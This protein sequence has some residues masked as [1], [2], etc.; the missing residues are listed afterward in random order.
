VLQRAFTL[1]ELIVVIGIFAVIMAV[2][3][4]N[5][6]ALNS[7]ILIN[8]FAYEIALNIRE[9]QAY[10]IGVRAQGDNVTVDS[11]KGAFAIY[12]TTQEPNL[13]ILYQDI[14]DDHAYQV[15][16]SFLR[17]Q[18]PKANGSRITAIC[19]NHSFVSNG[20]CTTASPTSDTELSISFKR[21]N[22]EA[23]FSSSD[24]GP[25]SVKSG[26]AVIVVN[27]ASGKN[28]KAVVVETTGQIHIESA[29]SVYPACIN[30]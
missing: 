27:N 19:V 10:G 20:P 3:M 11:F 14:N 21:P 15:D 18:L 4:Y 23:S 7:S 1:V 30:Q 2:A 9:A 12:S 17:L 22:P 13:Q 25:V 26:P 6:S 29:Q 24:G 5:Q 28:C 8:N 16:E